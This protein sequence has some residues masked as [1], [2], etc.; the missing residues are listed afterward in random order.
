MGLASFGFQC[1]LS[2]LHPGVFT[3]VFYYRDWIME[4]WN[5]AADM[6]KH[7]TTLTFVM[8]LFMNLIWL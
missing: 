7:Y 4:N 8:M 3:D 5:S 1:G 6:Q 2:A